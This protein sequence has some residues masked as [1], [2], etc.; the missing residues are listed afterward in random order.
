MYKLNELIKSSELI[1]KKVLERQKR[2]RLNDGCYVYELEADTTIPSEYIMLMH[3]LGDINLEL[4]EKI[5]RYLIKK[6][7]NQGGWALYHNGETNISVSVKA[8]FALKLS[9]HNKDSKEM[10]T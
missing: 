7:N 2:N 1:V 3:Y 5:K 6:Q 9:G 4:Q 8:Y 10:I